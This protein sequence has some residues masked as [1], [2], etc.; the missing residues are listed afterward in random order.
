[1]QPRLGFLYVLRDKAEQS[2][3]ENPVFETIKSLNVTGGPLEQFKATLECLATKLRPAEG[4]KKVGKALTWH[5]QKGEVDD[6]LSTIDRLKSQ[7]NLALQ[8]DHMFALYYYEM[9][10]NSGLS[11]TM[12]RDVREVRDKV[13]AIQLGQKGKKCFVYSLY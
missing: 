2:T 11:Q 9:L 5:F 4:L 6:L 3:P 13:A 12:G 10:T 1:M 7:F 8:N